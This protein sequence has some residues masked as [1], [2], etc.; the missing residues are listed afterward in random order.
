[1]TALVTYKE[2]VEWYRRE[3]S[4]FKPDGRKKESKP[5]Q[6]I[7][8][9]RL[10]LLVGCKERAAWK[11]LNNPGAFEGSNAQLMFDLIMRVPGAL[12]Y[13]ME[14]VRPQW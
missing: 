6:R 7:N 9:R 12:D 4:P 14:Q 13:K 10:G 3:K 11:Y 1:M 5:R 2:L 8:V